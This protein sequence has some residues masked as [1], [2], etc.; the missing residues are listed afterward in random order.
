MRVIRSLLALTALSLL[1]LSPAVA[2]ADSTI[3]GVVSTIV[4]VSA[5]STNTITFNFT[6]A[7]QT[8]GCAGN[9]AMICP[10]GNGYCQFSSILYHEIYAAL[11][12][13]KKAGSQMSCT[14][15]D[16]NYCQVTSCTLP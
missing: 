11:L 8:K 3:T 2:R 12:I 7:S 16:K 5:G 6:D 10:G 13:S 1:L 9:V 14:V 15:A 4:I